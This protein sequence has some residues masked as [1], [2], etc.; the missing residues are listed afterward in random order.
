MATAISSD[1][2]VILICSFIS[3]LFVTHGILARLVKV[4]HFLLVDKLNYKNFLTK[5]PNKNYNKNY[6]NILLTTVLQ[7]VILGRFTFHNDVN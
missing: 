2:S 4:A 5:E 3:F 6:N 7:I 1:N